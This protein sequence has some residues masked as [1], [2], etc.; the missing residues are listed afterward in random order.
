MRNAVA[1]LA[2]GR[3]ARIAAKF[4]RVTVADLS[5]LACECYSLLGAGRKHGPRLRCPRAFARW[6]LERLPS[7]RRSFAALSKSMRCRQAARQKMQPI[8]VSDHRSASRTT[9]AWLESNPRKLTRSVWSALQR[10]ATVPWSLPAVVCRGCGSALCR[11]GRSGLCDGCH[12]DRQRAT[13]RK[14]R[15]VERVAAARPNRLIDQLMN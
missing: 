7:N 3:S 1:S 5:L 13:D 2:S 12:S 9:K 14:R 6:C 15:R 11:R 10:R 4:G 8:A